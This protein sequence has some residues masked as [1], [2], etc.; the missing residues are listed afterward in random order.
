MTEL[1]DELQVV[2]SKQ[3]LLEMPIIED[4]HRPLSPES[5]PQVKPFPSLFPFPARRDGTN[6]NP[7]E[8]FWHF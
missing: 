2:T 8:W 7:C 6:Q 3:V 5:H 4:L 1:Q